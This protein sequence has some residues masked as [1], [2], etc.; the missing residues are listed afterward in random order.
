MCALTRLELAHAD[1]GPEGARELAPPLA[2]LPALHHLSLVGNLRLGAVGVAA[3][4]VHLGECDML[5]EVALAG[6]GVVQADAD[7]LAAQVPNPSDWPDSEACAADNGGMCA[8]VSW[9][10][11]ASGDS[12]WSLSAG[13]GDSVSCASANGYRKGSRARRLSSR[14]S[15]ASSS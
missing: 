3:L 1:I 4:G 13:K 14:A 5:A 11:G 6:C 7:S 9:A 15:D 8:Q 12:V 2:T 10:D